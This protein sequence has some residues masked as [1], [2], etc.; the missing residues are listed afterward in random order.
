[1][2]KYYDNAEAYAADPLYK[3]WMAF[4]ERVYARIL[5]PHKY[6]RLVDQPVPAS[7]DD[8]VNLVANK[9]V[10][11]RRATAELLDALNVSVLCTPE[12]EVDTAA[13]PVPAHSVG[14]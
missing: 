4:D 7:T 6:G 2:E 10:A 5:A 13:A 11:I 12:R 9:Y 3:Q 14:Q 8:Y 1:M